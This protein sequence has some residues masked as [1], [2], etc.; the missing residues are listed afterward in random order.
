MR[1]KD[2]KRILR[3]K[4]DFIDHLIEKIKTMEEEIENK[5]YLLSI[6]DNY[7]DKMIQRYYRNITSFLDK[8]F[9]FGI[10]ISIIIC[11]IIL[12]HH[13]NVLNHLK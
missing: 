11:I 7:Y 2:F 5:N 4:N 3:K 8:M 12:I 1:E 10:S 13:F 9:C 6:R